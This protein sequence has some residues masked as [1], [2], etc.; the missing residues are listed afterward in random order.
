MSSTGPAPRE[1]AQGA[2]AAPDPRLSTV[3]LG[4]F[5]HSMQ[6]SCDAN[7][8]VEDVLLP[9]HRILLAAESSGL[10]YCTN[11]TTS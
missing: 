10:A 1:A 7:L 3:Y 5:G 2:N 6:T 11:I 8:L 4:R 9:C